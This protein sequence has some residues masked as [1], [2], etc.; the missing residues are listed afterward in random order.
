MPVKKIK[1]RIIG[2][3]PMI[4]FPCGFFNGAADKN[5]GGA[6]FV[7]HFS[8]SHNIH[9]SM[10]CDRCTNTKAEM[11]ALWGLLTVSKM[12]GIPLHSIHGDS[13]V[14]ISWAIG[15]NS[16]NLPHLSHWGDD[17]RDLLQN[18]PELIVK[19]I[20]REHNQI[21]DILSKNALLLDSGYGNYKEILNE[22][23]TDHGNFQLF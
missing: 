9:F 8:S 3:S 4:Q 1:H 6:G 11:M 19:H 16:L 12:M 22:F 21:A 17:I 5:K 7:L 18:F 15:K 10:G 13:L 2:M 23:S 20:Y 14:I